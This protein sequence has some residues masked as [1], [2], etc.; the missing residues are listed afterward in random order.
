[1]PNPKRLE[2]NLQREKDRRRDEDKETLL[3]RIA[4]LEA[5]L[6]GAA[7]GHRS[8]EPSR[9]GS[10]LA[11]KSVGLESGA[12]DR[13]MSEQPQMGY[14]VE[15][16]TKASDRTFNEWDVRQKEQNTSVD[17]VGFQ[18]GL[19]GS[20]STGNASVADVGMD[21]EWDFTSLFLLPAQWPKNLPTPCESCRE[22][23]RFTRA[24][25]AVLLDHLYA[26]SPRLYA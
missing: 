16:K 9:S 4:E 22:K 10:S 11:S 8:T 18:V 14:P 1:M 23:S 2:R 19:D 6:G 7:I 17:E 26:A 5:R 12:S 20:N 13:W 24:H 25:H 3:A 21:P 15:R